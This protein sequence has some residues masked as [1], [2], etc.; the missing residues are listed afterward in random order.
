MKQKTNDYLNRLYISPLE[1]CNLNCQMCYTRKI[2]SILSEKAILNFIDQYQVKHKLQTITFCG[3][4]VFTLS[5]FSH[6]INRL[7]QKGIFIQIITNGTIDALDNFTQPNSIDLIVSI[8]GLKNYHDQNRGSGN[9]EKSIKFL[10]KAKKLGFHT[11]IFTIV[12]RQN[13]PKL[14]EFENNIKKI[15]NYD[16]A[17]TYHPRKPMAYLQN[18]P[19]SNILGKTEGFDFLD[20][21]EMTNLLNNRRTFPPKEFGCYQISLM[22]DGKI[23]GCCEGTVPIGT[24]DNEIETLFNNLR[25]RLNNCPSCSQPDFVCGLK[26]Y[27]I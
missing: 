19:V 14:D 12:T 27:L 3:G 8:D 2:N 15:L 26:D 20:R 4:E 1:K 6:L 22:S 17:I 18:H 16:I 10:K 9:F 23:Y 24:I 5:Y 21:A 7:T 13:Y 25:D 11:E